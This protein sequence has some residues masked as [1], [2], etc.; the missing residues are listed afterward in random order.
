M[1]AGGLGLG[2]GEG[3]CWW[4]VAA[5]RGMDTELF[6]LPSSASDAETALARGACAACR[7]SAECLAAAMEEEGRRGEESRFGLRGGLTPRQRARLYG[8]ERD[9][10][11]RRRREALRGQVEEG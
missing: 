5:C 3:L 2:L 10:R 6:F 4:Q 9:A 8:A 7:V 1:S 11:S